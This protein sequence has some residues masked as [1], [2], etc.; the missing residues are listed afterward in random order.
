MVEE[1]L[2]LIRVTEKD[3]YDAHESGKINAETC[4]EKRLF[5]EAVRLVVVEVDLSLDGQFEV[6][7]SAV[8]AIHEI[9]VY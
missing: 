3:I 2:D 5:L 9:K 4:I 8:D 6:L 7:E 1:V